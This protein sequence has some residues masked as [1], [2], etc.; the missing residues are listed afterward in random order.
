MTS[1]TEKRPPQSD[2]GQLDKF[3]ELAR[4]LEAD[5]DEGRWDER[6]RLVATRSP[7]ADDL[8][9]EDGPPATG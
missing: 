9:P 7:K 3:K 4:Q 5:E 2:S 8:S 1:R 6:L